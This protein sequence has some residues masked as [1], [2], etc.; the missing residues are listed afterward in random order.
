MKLFIFKSIIIT[1]CLIILSYFWADRYQF[2]NETIRGNKITGE[3]EFTT[4]KG[5]I[6]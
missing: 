6:Y 3:V 5:R 1:L 4:L 2:I